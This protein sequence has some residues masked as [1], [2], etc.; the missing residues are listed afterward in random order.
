MNS[1]SK[2]NPRLKYAIG[3]GI[4]MGVGTAIYQMVTADAEGPDFVRA[5]F[6]GIFGFIGFLLVPSKS[7]KDQK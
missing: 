6:V 4:G 3:M 1:E 5:L 7:A 2:K